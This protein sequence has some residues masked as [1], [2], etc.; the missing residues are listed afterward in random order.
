[1]N[2][3]SEETEEWVKAQN[4]ETKHYV[5]AYSGRD[6]IK[7][8]ITRLMDYPK[9]S[10]PTKEGDYYYFHYNDGLQNQPIF[11]RT[12]G[13]SSSSKEMVIDPNTINDK[14]T[15]ALTNLAFSQDGSKL[16]YGVS[17]DGSDWQTIKI[18]DLHTGEDYPEKL[19][20]CKFSAI[21]WTKDEKGFYYNR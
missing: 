20:W 9:Y 16:A 4:K 7:K 10:L 5:A 11:Y 13:I 8:E 14:G 6:Q 19:K 18:K 21:A 12:K 2:P 3:D 1:E 17:L 15:A